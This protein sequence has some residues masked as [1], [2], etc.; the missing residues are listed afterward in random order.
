MS[1]LQVDNIQTYNSNPPVIKNVNGTQIGT[2][3]RAWVNFDGTGTVAIRQ[4]FNV[5]SITDNGT[6]NYTVNL[7]TAMPDT[8]YCVQ[9]CGVN[10]GVSNAFAFPEVAS[11][12]TL[13]LQTA[14]RSA[15]TTNADINGIYVTVFR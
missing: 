7:T 11:S 9:S 6:G 1:S 14:T 10:G 15:P 5:S 8:S 2:F 13:T 4:S 12:S 3:C